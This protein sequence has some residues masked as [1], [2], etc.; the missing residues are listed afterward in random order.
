[1][2]KKLQDIKQ[3]NQINDINLKG[4]KKRPL[5]ADVLKEKQHKFYKNHTPINEVRDL[6]TDEKKH[7]IYVKGEKFHP[8][9]SLGN[10]LK[11]GFFGFL[12]I[13][14]INTINVYYTT[15]RLEKNI[16]SEA[17]QGYSLLMD[18]GRSA[19]KVQFDNASESF[20]K[21]IK[22]FDEVKNELWFLS[23]DKSYYSAQNNIGSS[24][25]ALI[26]GGEHFTSA[27]QHFL[28]A[29]EEFNKVPLYFVTKNNNPNAS[30]PSLTDTLKNGLGKTDL[31]IKE[32]N[33]AS[34]ELATVNE[35]NLPGEIAP[36]V[37]AVKS[38]VQMVSDT[39]NATASHFPALLKLLGDQYPHRYLILLQNNNEIRPSGGFIGS[40]AIVDIDKG[41]IKKIDIQDVYDIDGS[42]KDI[43]EPPDYMKQFISNWRF[44]DSNYSADF[45]T[46]ASKAKWFLAKEGGPTVDTVIAINQGLLQD[47]LDIT[48]PI[49]VGNFGKLNSE[50]Y[51]LLLSYV[52]EGK[53]W[54]PENPKHILKMFIPAFQKEIMKEENIG[55]VG[56]KLYKAIQQKHIMM[57]SADADVEG[58]FDSLGVSGRMYQNKP[59]EDY[60]SVVN[61][62]AGGTKSDLFLE[63]NILHD[64]YIDKNG[65]LTDEVTIKHVHQW[66]DAVYFQ[67]KKTLQSYGLNQMPDQLIDILGRGRNKSII[68]IYVP[69]GSILLNSTDPNLTLQYDKDVKK[70]YFLATMEITAGKTG[71]L[72]FKYRLP[73][74]L[75]LNK[76][77]ANY[78]LIVDKQ[79]GSRG[80][81]FTKTTHTDPE[82]SNISIYPKEAKIISGTEISYPTNLVYD[83][84]FSGIWKK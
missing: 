16:S 22:N 69:E 7:F 14:F 20:Q 17:Y 56:S 26:V 42:F 79:P 70:N 51:N 3:E 72:R 61:F 71:Y 83:R 81:I 38:Q 4:E 65:N 58:L 78:K 54:G 32:I 48:G 21:A 1:M 67:W 46:S 23:T 18:A 40:Y 35:K 6:K 30:G 66:T 15:K 47:M 9:K 77:A 11:I 53:I 45:P 75:D 73:F 39:L 55:K 5:E 28:D 50:N 31:A 12:I 44:R 84:Y 41:V 60:L 80:S 76:S 57:Y 29:L 25:K 49:Q 62:S 19:S 68:K 13:L 2:S 43:I 64:T 59:E 27:G 24:V 33:L 8:P 37:A 36:R 52:I 63:E 82:I 10:L 74:L 34:Q